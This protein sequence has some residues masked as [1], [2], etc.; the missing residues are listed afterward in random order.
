MKISGESTFA[1]INLFHAQVLKPASRSTSLRTFV[2][3]A[4]LSEF[5]YHK[6]FE[7]KSP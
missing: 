4:Q 5:Y 7:T 6:K 1:L 3:L 2:F